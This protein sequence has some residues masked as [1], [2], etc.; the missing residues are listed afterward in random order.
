MVKVLIHVCDIVTLQIYNLNISGGIEITGHQTNSFQYI[1]KLITIVFNLLAEM[2]DGEKKGVRK[3]RQQ[4][5][6]NLMNINCILGPVQLFM[7]KSQQSS[8]HPFCSI[9][10]LQY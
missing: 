4:E 8:I 5:K 10:I 3:E 6:G 7:G 2:G 1:T 9:S